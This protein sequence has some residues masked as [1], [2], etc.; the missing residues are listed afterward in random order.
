MYLNFQVGALPK[1]DWLVLAPHPDDETFGMGGAISKA[2]HEDCNVDVLVMTDGA[3]GG[4]QGNLREIRELEAKN[5][6][7]IL[8]CRSIE[9]LGQPDRNL[10][11]NSNNINEVRRKITK[12]NY[13]AIYFPSPVEPH[14]DHRATAQIAW[15]AIRICSFPCEAFSYEISVQGPC[16][17]LIDITHNL[18]KKLAAM[19]AYVSQISHTSYIDRILAINKSRSWSLE[20]SVEYVE[21]FHKWDKRDVPLSSLLRDLH[22][23]KESTCALPDPEI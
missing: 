23:L 1:G 11:I 18:G 16:N 6:A 13:D 3:L 10:L 12:N 8:G 2:T 21:A 20:K 9:F 7:R 22:R 5:A 17:I 14:P 4:I 19:N 15:E